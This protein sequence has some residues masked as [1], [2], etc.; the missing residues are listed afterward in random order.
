MKIIITESKL[1]NVAVR[2]LNHEYGDLEPYETDNYPNYIFFMKDGKIIFDY[3]KKNGKVFVDN[4]EI[5]RVL[6]SYLKIESKQIQVLVKLWVEEYY[7]LNVTSVG[8]SL[9]QPDITN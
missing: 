7:G 8:K 9:I 6:D 1:N 2:W 5:W 4:N 3:D